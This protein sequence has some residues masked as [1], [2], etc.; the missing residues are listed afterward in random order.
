MINS[1]NFRVVWWFILVIALGIYLFFRHAQ[2]LAGNPTYFD[3]VVFL[4]WIAICLA[5]VFKDVKLFGL[6]LKQDID[7]LKKDLSHQMAMMKVELQSSIDVSATNTSHVHINGGS[8]LPAKDS[9]I[10]DIKQQ[11]FE[12]LREF[13]V[14]ERQTGETQLEF[15]DS[16]PSANVDLFKIRLSFERLVNGYV[17]RN[18]IDPRRTSLHRTLR[19]LMRDEI[20]SPK[21]VNGVLEVV[22]ICNYAIH[23]E[24]VS[25]EQV[26]FVKESAGSLYK[27]L[28]WELQN[29]A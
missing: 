28:A 1:N 20:V 26:S 27:A 14:P 12:A 7:Q 8:P 2:L 21:I 15:I 3:T 29:N 13:N 18:G 4:V 5:P 23:G 11:V 6:H 22:A 10:P 9:E 19:D 24:K 16:I 25:E 17:R